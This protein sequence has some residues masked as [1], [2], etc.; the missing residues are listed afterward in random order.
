MNINF[1]LYK[2]FYEVANAGSISKGA[3]NLMISQPAVSQ[4]IQTLENELGG[5]LFVRTP[6]GVILTNEGKEL[7]SYI[8]EG[9]TY[10]IN[11]T[12]KF[13]SL[14]SLESGVLNIGASASISENYLMPYLAEYRRLYPNV[15]VSIVND[16]TDNLIKELRNGNLD[17]VIA[18]IPNNTKD[19]KVEFV[20]DLHDIFVSCKKD[21]LDNLNG[22]LL[23]KRPSVTR[24]NFDK[25]VESNNIDFDCKMEIVSHRL[26]INF[27]ENGFGVGLV[28]KEFVKEK[29][30]KSLYEVDTKYVVPTR[31]LSYAIKDDVYP[32]FTT[33]KFIELLKES[34]Y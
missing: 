1:E 28:T 9:M 21:K 14:K 32:T 34:K 23:Q 31:K 20:C 16:L 2:V 17:I 30:G 24:N 22:I 10:F 19:L 6:K 26:L 18:S 27:I 15:K 7:F 25:Y 3:E 13:M 29:L 5:K 4:S 11:G 8:K 12:N 33:K